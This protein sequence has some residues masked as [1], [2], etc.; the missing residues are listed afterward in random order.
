MTRE[1]I[2]NANKTAK[3]AKNRFLENLSNTI[4]MYCELTVVEYS[5]YY[6][7]DHLKSICLSAMILRDHSPP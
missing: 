4:E 5:L 7:S 6:S 2:G 3:A 1:K